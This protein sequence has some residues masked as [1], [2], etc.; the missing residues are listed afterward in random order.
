MKRKLTYSLYFGVITLFAYVI[1]IPYLLHVSGPTIEQLNELVDTPITTSQYI[2]GSGIN[3]VLITF[4]F[5]MIGIW[6]SPKVGLKWSWIRALF[7]KQVKPR[8]DRPFLWMAVVWG[9]IST[10][11]ITLLTALVF[12][13]NIP[14]F[15]EI[16][17]E[18]D[19]PWWVG[20]TTVF[21]GGISEELMMRFGLM[22]LIV[23]LL[24]KV[25]MR[26]REKREVISPWVYW[27]AIIGAS[28]VFGFGHLSLAQSVYGGN[29]LWVILYVLIGNGFAGL[30]FG[31][32]YWKRGLEY[33]IVS[34]MTA[35]LMLHFVIPLLPF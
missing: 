15:T 19:M 25:F 2:L 20:L 9:V 17:E 7:D 13:K 4:L 24:S 26:K 22:T 34:H 29:S 32:F 6:L 12:A 11:F 30:G 18:M 5:S 3:I 21:Q 14:N 28:L 31:Y 35:D 16:N 10:V 27:I 1:S 23:W 8:W 33:A